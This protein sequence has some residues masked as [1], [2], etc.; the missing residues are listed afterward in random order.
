MTG[1]KFRGGYDPIFR[2]KLLT[3]GLEEGIKAV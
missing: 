3:C 2:K 1:N